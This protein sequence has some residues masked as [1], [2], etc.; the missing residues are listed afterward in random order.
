M[1]FRH[2]LKIWDEGKFVSSVVAATKHLLF[3]QSKRS[4][5]LDVQFQ[6][7]INGLSLPQ[8]P[9]LIKHLHLTPTYTKYYPCPECNFLYPLNDET[10]IPTRCTH[11][12]TA[13]SLPCDRPLGTVLIKR[14]GCK[15]VYTRTYLHHSFKDWVGE[16]LCRQGMEELLDRDVYEDGSTENRKDVW[17][18]DVLR[19]FLRPDGKTFVSSGRGQRTNTD[20]HYMFAFCWDGFNP[21]GSK[22]A[23]KKPSACAL[24]LMCLNL[25]LP[26]RHFQEN[27][28]LV[29]V[30]PGPYEPSKHQINHYLALMVDELIEFWERGV[31]YTR[32]AKYPYGR[33]VSVA[34]ALTI[35]D[36]LATRQ[37]AGSSHH[38]SRHLCQ[39]CKQSRDQINKLDWT[40]WVPRTDEEHR[41]NGEVWRDAQTQDERQKLHEEYGVRRTEFNRLPYWKPVTYVGI[42]SMHLFYLGLLKRHVRGIWGFDAEYTDGDGTERRVKMGPIPPRDKLERAFNL[43]KDKEYDRLK[44]SNT[45]VLRYLCK[46]L[47]CL[48]PERDWKRK[49]PLIEALKECVSVSYF[50]Q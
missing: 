22:E 33:T 37:A 8:I 5:D 14:D 18:G 35:C 16:L 42:D 32:T 48:P 23:G 34:L 15:T 25:P 46:S 40:N 43:L 17:D 47:Q 45:S 36:M 10:S 20:G 38:S 49:R 6:K 7:Y 3:H 24:Y 44:N 1:N 27:I 21:L 41:E 31:R 13:D 28:F 2:Y 29:G 26:D 39:F 30:I 11:K 9:T 4:S 12:E 19:N 50:Y